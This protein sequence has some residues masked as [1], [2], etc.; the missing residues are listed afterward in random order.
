M[1]VPPRLST[2]VQVTLSVEKWLKMV[3]FSSAVHFRHQQNTGVS[4]SSFVLV[5]LFLVLCFSAPSA[6]GAWRSHEGEQLV[7]VCVC[8]RRRLTFRRRAFRCARPGEPAAAA[9]REW[10]IRERELSLG[11][12]RV[13]GGGVGGEFACATLF[14]P[15]QFE[16]SLSAKFDCSRE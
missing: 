14:G 9:A 12:K 6:E 16:R 1:R 7:C 10:P 15:L 8:C 2:R 4:S 3:A 13:A 11:E 5:P